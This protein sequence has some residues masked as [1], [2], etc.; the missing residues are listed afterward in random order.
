MTAATTQNIIHTLKKCSDLQNIHCYLYAK[1]HHIV[2]TAVYSRSNVGAS[3]CHL[4]PPAMAW[5]T[6]I[7]WH[8]NHNTRNGCCH[9]RKREN[10][11]VPCGPCVEKVET[12]GARVT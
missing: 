4:I 6:H 7:I 8:G 11:S 3:Q 9:W 12:R 2:K 10:H 5:L 1:L